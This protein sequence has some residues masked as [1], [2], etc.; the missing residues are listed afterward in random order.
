MVGAE[1]TDGSVAVAL[2]SA[3]I[4]YAGLPA[5][6]PVDEA[7]TLIGNV[8]NASCEIPFVAFPPGIKDVEACV[9]AGFSGVC[10]GRQIFEEADPVSVIEEL[11]AMLTK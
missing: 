11:L 6:M 9:N 10:M 5:T 4:D 1:V 7:S 3:D 8:R 2:A